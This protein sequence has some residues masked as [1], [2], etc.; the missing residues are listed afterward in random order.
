MEETR[1]TRA[2]NVSIDRCGD[3]ELKNKEN[4]HVHNGE[5]RLERC[6]VNVHGRLRLLA[7]EAPLAF[8]CWCCHDVFGPS[9]RVCV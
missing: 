1:L 7:G 6:H 2:Q 9:S 5:R 3:E 4:R 8:L